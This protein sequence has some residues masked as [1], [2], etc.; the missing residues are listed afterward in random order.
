MAEA[1]AI[2][3][4]GW[5]GSRLATEFRGEI[6]RADI[7]DRR[8]LMREM[9]RLNPTVVINAAGKTGR[10]NID[11]CEADPVGTLVANTAGPIILAE[12]CLSRGVFMAHLGSGCVY[13]N[14]KPSYTEEDPPNFFG[15]VYSRSK[16][17]SEAALKNLPVLQLRIRMPFS[18]ERSSRNL[19]TKLAGYQ[20]VISVPNS[21]TYI[22][23]LVTA[24]E[25][26]ITARRTGI[27]NVVNPEPVTHDQ[28]LNLY[29]EIVDPMHEFQVMSTS[30]LSS[31]TRAGRSNCVLDGTKLERE[32]V[33]MTPTLEALKKSLDLYRSFA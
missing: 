25:H 4:N 22:D 5:I 15:S 3:G 6:A 17:L 33:L 20:K 19:I 30:E 11:G 27:W 13:D 24:A 1:F 9:D 12:E 28:I 29:R 2:F 31:M 8:D 26:L 7:T 32:G 16:M 10:P 23:D 18:G 21:M 14:S